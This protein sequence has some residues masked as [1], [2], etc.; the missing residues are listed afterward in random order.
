M[1]RLALISI[2]FAI[3]ASLPC[4]AATYG[5]PGGTTGDVSVSASGS[6]MDAKIEAET[7]KLGYENAKL[8]EELSFPSWVRSPWLQVLFAFLGGLFAAGAAAGVA[9]IP[10]VAV[11]WAPSMKQWL[12][13][14]WRTSSPCRCGPEVIRLAIAFEPY[15]PASV[16]KSSHRL[17]NEANLAFHRRPPCTPAVVPKTYPITTLHSRY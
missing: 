3:G 11:G 8:A 10:R 2:L 17:F 5:T 12:R 14:D 16:S 13:S 9:L 15:F 4:T 6:G 7:R 1:N